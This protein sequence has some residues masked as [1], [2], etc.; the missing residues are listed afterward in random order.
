MV[1]SS[2]QKTMNTS[3]DALTEK[4]NNKRERER[5]ES[6]T[7]DCLRIIALFMVVTLHWLIFAKPHMRDDALWVGLFYTP[8][9]AG[10]WIFFLIGGYLAGKS[11]VS[12]RYELTILGI[13]KYYVRRFVRLAPSYYLFCFLCII[14]FNPTFPFSFWQTCLEILTFTYNGIPGVIGIGAT[15]YISTTMQLYILAPL[16]ISILLILKKYINI[17]FIFLIFLGSLL[18]IISYLFSIDFYT[19]YT[20][21]YGNID[22]FLCG[23]CINFINIKQKI[24]K[25]YIHISASI[26]ICTNMILY[27][28]ESYLSMFIYQ[29]ILPTIY[30]LIFSIIIYNAKNSNKKNTININNLFYK[31]INKISYIS[32]GIYLWH[33]N[34]FFSISKAMPMSMSF[35]QASGWFILSISISIF[36]GFI[37]EKSINSFYPHR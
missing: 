5:E 27:F 29:Y 21:F 22:I 13:K 6:L 10:V 18:R 9:W 25:L 35:L 8:A 20:S 15:W 1:S 24:N 23:I 14:F 4:I 28:I 7:I 19:I 2:L 30:I 34:I 3:L 17:V 26:L 37:Y 16:F 31:Y 36:V 32:L 33:S 11:F 12:G